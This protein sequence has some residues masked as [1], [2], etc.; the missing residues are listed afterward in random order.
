L[1]PNVVV[2]HQIDCCGSEIAIGIGQAQQSKFNSAEDAWR[3]ASTPCNCA[4]RPTRA[5]DGT[6]GVDIGVKCN[7]ATDPGTC[8]S[9]SP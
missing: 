5:E 3:A 9:V 4:P 2:F 7:L 8:E 6:T 1:R